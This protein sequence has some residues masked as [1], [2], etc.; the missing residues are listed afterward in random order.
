MKALGYTHVIF[1]L[2]LFPGT[3][4]AVLESLSSM[5]SLVCVTM[6]IARAAGGLGVRCRDAGHHVMAHT[7]NDVG[8]L[9]RLREES[10]VADVYSDFLRP[11]VS[12][13]DLAS[14]A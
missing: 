6:P 13:L 5:P 7:V 3:D 4:D 11:G 1:T 10:G 2:Y 8:E 12:S 9:R 14:M